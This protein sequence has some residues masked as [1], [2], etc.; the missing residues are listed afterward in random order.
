LEKLSKQTFGKLTFSSGGASKP[1]R[2]KYIV[3]VD[4]FV[5][6]PRFEL[7]LFSSLLLQA[8]SRLL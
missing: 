3:V 2:S 5:Q 7:H 6:L 4:R 8:A 1:H